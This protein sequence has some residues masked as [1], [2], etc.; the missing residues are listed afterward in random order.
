MYTQRAWTMRQYAGFG[1]AD[2][3]NRRFLTLLERGQTGL[4]VA[5]DLPT[6]MGM[7]SDDPRADGEVGR[8]GVAIDSLADMER[9][10]KGI[11]LD[12]VSISMTINAPAAILWAM[13]LVVAQRQGIPWTV[14]RGTIQND[15]LKEFVARG[16]YIFSPEASMRLVRETLSFQSQV[17]QF[18]PISVS[19]Y[20]IREAGATAAL[21][22]GITLAHSMAYLDA[23]E[24]EGLD[25]IAVARR[26]SFFF[27]CHNDFLE[28]V[29]KFRAARVLWSD[30]LQKRGITDLKARKLRFH[31]QT[32]GST[33]IRNQPLLNVARVAIQAL[34]ATLGGTQSLH[35]NAFDEA[36][37]L[38]G[39]EA[40]LM[41]LRTQQVLYYETGLARTVDPLGGSAFLEKETRRLVDEAGG[42]VEL[43]EE[44]GGGVAA[45]KSGLTASLIQEASAQ[46]QGEIERG[47]RVVVG[48]NRFEEGVGASREPAPLPKGTGAEQTQALARR[49]DKRDSM[50]VR[51]A[52][53]A[54]EKGAR[55][56]GGIMELILAAVKTEAT[57]G[58]IVEVFTKSWGR[59][60]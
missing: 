60:R 40:A 21:E 28:E 1:S 44:A 51:V 57:L 39:E 31:T 35:T 55:G 2:E 37:G 16:C 48:L 14:L 27:G 49:R 3:T 13:V 52:L 23:A 54:L 45:V 38:P 41:A 8:T 5:F 56:E 30:L 7:D 25:L 15:I 29:A 32:C 42:V 17:P 22:V 6:Q 58:E 4:S 12:K 26:F 10:L 46:S 43:I 20:H 9:L 53:G 11:P 18:N 19:G 33:L 50:A 34:A 47:D 36:I 59:T 24:A